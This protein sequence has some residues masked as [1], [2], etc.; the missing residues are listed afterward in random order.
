MTVTWEEVKRSREQSPERKR[1]Y[2][3]ARRLHHTG[4]TVRALRLERGLSQRELSRQAGVS[5]STLSRLE[6]GEGM[7]AVAALER[8]SEALGARLE[9]AIVKG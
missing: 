7:P 2:E 5:V 3:H 8:I 1:G 6:S 4:D 9:M